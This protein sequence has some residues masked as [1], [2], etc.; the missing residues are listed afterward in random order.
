MLALGETRDPAG[1]S[2]LLKIAEDLIDDAEVRAVCTAIALNR[3]N[4]AVDA[5]I[6]LVRTGTQ[7]QS[8]A[9]AQALEVFTS[10]ES[11]GRRLRAALEARE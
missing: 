2:L 11:V 7:R 10:D 1:L 8:E 6:E 4:E 5:L 9:A 3:S